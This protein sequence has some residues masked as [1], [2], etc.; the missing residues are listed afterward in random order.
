VTISAVSTLRDR[1]AATKAFIYVWLSAILE[2]AVKDSLTAL[3]VELNSAGVSQDKV[4]SSLFS[5][6]CE[7]ELDSI[8]DRKRQLGWES[9]V[10]LFARVIDKTPAK[11][12]PQILPLDNRTLRGEHFDTIWLVFGLPGTSLPSHLHRAALLD[13]AEGR[14]EVAHGTTQPVSFGKAKATSDLVKLAS[15]VEDVICHLVIALED[16]IAKKHYVR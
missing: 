1:A 10:A 12:L 16:F 14:N 11:F 6:L 5:L 3:L 8:S 2:K 15:R 9:R 7:P 13:L 4:R